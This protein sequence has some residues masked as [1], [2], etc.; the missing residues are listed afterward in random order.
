MKTVASQEILTIPCGNEPV[1]LRQLRP[2]LTTSGMWVALPVA[3]H[4]L[5]F[6]TRTTAWS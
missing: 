1:S 6:P 5:P 2:I 4:S 3:V